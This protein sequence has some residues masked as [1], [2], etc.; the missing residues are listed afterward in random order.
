MIRKIESNFA[1]CQQRRKLLSF[2]TTSYFVLC[3]HTRM[4]E[5]RRETDRQREKQYLITYQI[6]KIKCRVTLVLNAQKYITENYQSLVLN[7]SVKTQSICGI[8]M[9]LCTKYKYLFCCK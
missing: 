1:D 4:H 3:A 6:K 5:G 8:D 2:L 7:L 9:K